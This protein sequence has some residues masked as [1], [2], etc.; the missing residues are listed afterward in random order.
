[1]QAYWQG[2]AK[3]PNFDIFWQKA[4]H[5]GVVPNTAL[6]AVNVTAKMPPASQ[7]K[8]AQGMEII[9]RPDPT[10]WDGSFANNG[11]LQE[12]PKPQN[13]MTW[14]NAVWISP[15]TAQQ[16][17]LNIGDM[18]ELKYQGRTITGPIW[19]MPGHANNSATVH[20]GFGRTFAGHVG[21]EVGFNA[22]L[23]RTSSAPWSDY[24]AELNKVGGKPRIRNHAAHADHGRGRADSHRHSRR[25]QEDAAV[26]RSKGRRQ[27][28]LPPN[29]PCIR[30]I[31]IKATSGA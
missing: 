9:F 30:T 5:D 21:N 15:T 17:N 26:R 8:T 28:P 23:L 20:L 3:V 16:K 14:D 7:P 10:I 18:V 4:L 25:V 13:K 31:A 6:P 24:G 1:M 19:I 2:Q 22:Y 29:S 11:W 12:L 27:K